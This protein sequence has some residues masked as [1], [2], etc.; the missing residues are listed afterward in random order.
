MFLETTS[1]RYRKLLN[2]LRL[3]LESLHHV[4]S[5]QL[6]AFLYQFLHQYSLVQN[7]V[8]H[9]DL[10][11]DCLSFLKVICMLHLCDGHFILVFLFDPCQSSINLTII[12]VLPSSFL[13]LLQQLS[14]SLFLLEVHICQYHTLSFTHKQI[15]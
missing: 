10:C 3:V 1:T 7:C 11:L 2:L 8:V 4:F 13:H 12:T 6:V 9:L 15:L 5:R 14:I